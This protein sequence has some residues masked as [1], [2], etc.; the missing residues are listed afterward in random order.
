M[1]RLR[2]DM[3]HDLGRLTTRI[4]QAEHDRME[5]YYRQVSEL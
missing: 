2:E 3:N 5:K 4:E 1:N